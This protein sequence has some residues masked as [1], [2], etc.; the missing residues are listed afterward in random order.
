MKIYVASSWR[1]E[2]QQ[3]VVEMLRSLGHEVYDFKNPPHGRGGFHWS[4]IDPNWEN[5]SA[6][7][8]RDALNHPIAQEGF[9][10]DFDAMQ[11]A[12]CCLMILPCGR[13]ANTEAGWFKGAGRKVYIFLP[14]PQKHE[15]ELMYLMHD[16]VIINYPELL[17]IF[18]IVEDGNTGDQETEG[19][20]GQAEGAEEE[21][22]NTES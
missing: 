18:T 22:T 7:E 19:R 20:S 17:E 13:S 10:S 3:D 16:G 4:A 1:N 9:K 5:W 15:P 6:K 12:D 11:W 8:Y 14:G 21:K 2:H